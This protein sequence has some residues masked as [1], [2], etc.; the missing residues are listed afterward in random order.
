[1]R[2]PD[3]YRVNRTYAAHSAC[4]TCGCMLKLLRDPVKVVRHERVAGDDREVTE[5]VG[6][7]FK[8]SARV[9]GYVHTATMRCPR[10]GRVFS[11]A[12]AVRRDFRDDEL[13]ADY[14]VPDKGVEATAG[15]LRRL[16][17]DLRAGRATG[18][19]AA[20]APEQGALFEG[21][22]DVE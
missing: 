12:Q 9:K 14:L 16:V 17:A 13:P 4:P 10:C 3:G 11:P 21:A 8:G 7:G 5:T 1:M 6:D 19:P 2:V 22:G 18:A 20:A 15:M